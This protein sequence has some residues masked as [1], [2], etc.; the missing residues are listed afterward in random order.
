MA[1]SPNN[2]RQRVP[3]RVL[4]SDLHLR[5]P[6]LPRPGRKFLLLPG[7]LSNTTP[8]RSGSNLLHLPRHLPFP[9]ASRRTGSD[10][11]R[12]P[13][14]RAIVF[15]LKRIEFPGFFEWMFRLFSAFCFFPDFIPRSCFV[16][17]FVPLLSV[18]LPMFGFFRDFFCD[19][20]AG[21]VG[22]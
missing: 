16:S 6:P 1:L 11:S 7:T 5:A 8:R 9:T 22:I 13:P 15:R 10:L 4:R 2:T 18:Y 12:L 17:E 20:S 21:G 14:G 19:A 3:R